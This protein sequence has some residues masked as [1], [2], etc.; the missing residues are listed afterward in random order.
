[1]AGLQRPFIL[2]VVDGL[3]ASDTQA[4][5]FYLEFYAQYVQLVNTYS[6]GRLAIVLVKNIRSA[7][8]GEQQ[9]VTKNFNVFVIPAPDDAIV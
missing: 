3:E 5:S 8:F 4:L 1:M 9:L 2:V 6:T 7:V